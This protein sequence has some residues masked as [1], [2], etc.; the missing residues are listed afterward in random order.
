MIISNDMINN[1]IPCNGGMN[2]YS[3]AL[4]W[5][6]E[7]IRPNGRNLQQISNLIGNYV[8]EAYQFDKKTIK[9]SDFKWLVCQI[10]K[11]SDQQDYEFW[12]L[13]IVRIE[14]ALSF[15]ASRR[16][17]MPDWFKELSEKCRVASTCKGL[18][19]KV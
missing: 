11:N 4:P 6:E 3:N 8:G 10:I 17:P 12:L 9:M 7:L 15:Y 1:C 5:Y 2:R 14:A 16:G 19:F 18:Q 13:Q